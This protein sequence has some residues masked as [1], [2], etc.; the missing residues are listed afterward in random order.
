MLKT[1]VKLAERGVIGKV[2]FWFVV[3]EKTENMQFLDLVAIT[4]SLSNS[5][6]HLVSSSVILLFNVIHIFILFICTV[7]FM[8]RFKRYFF[9]N[10]LQLYEQQ[11][12]EDR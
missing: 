3:L 12:A 10:N 2:P 1:E 8:K 11:Q 7:Y 6:L 4:A 5:P 9:K